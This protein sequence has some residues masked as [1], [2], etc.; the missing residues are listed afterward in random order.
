MKQVL[1][2]RHGQSIRNLGLAA[3]DDS[4]APLTGGGL[5][6]RAVDRGGSQAGGGSQ[7]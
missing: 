1:L 3:E 2:L 4:R 7:P 5:F 6:A